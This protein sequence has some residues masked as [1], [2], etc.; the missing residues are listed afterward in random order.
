MGCA[1]CLAV[2]P[3]DAIVGARN[4]THTVIVSECIGC[5]RCLDPCPVDCI[6][7]VPAPQALVPKTHLARR[8]RA[9]RIRRRM[10][11]RQARLAWEAAAQRLKLAAKKQVLHE[12]TTAP[13]DF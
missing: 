5:K 4:F 9:Q 8:E 6:Q 2:C 13:P 10:L 11:A 7:L 12:S 1:R 3:V